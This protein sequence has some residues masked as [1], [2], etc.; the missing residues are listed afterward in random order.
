MQQMAMLAPELV[1]FS[2]MEL[3]I[4]RAWQHAHG[5]EL[6]RS[7]RI[8]VLAVWNVSKNHIWLNAPSQH[9]DELD[10][11]RSLVLILDDIAPAPSEEITLL[12]SRGHS[13]HPHQRHRIDPREDDRWSSARDVRDPKPSSRM[14]FPNL[15]YGLPN[16]RDASLAAAWR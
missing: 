1:D 7:A 12:E 8:A 4:R 6:R 9:A 14:P 5:L 16:Q 13:G 3:E 10:M 2:P 11:E 15:L